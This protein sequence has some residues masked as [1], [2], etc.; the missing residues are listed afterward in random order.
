MR[1]L[2]VVCAVLWM[3]LASAGAA[4]GQADGRTTRARLLEDGG[5]PPRLDPGRRAGH[6]RAGHRQ[7]VRGRRDRGRGRVHRRE[8]RPLRR[9]RLAL[10]HRRRARRGPAGGV[11]ALHPGRRRLRRRARRERHRVHVELVRRPRRRVLQR[12]PRIRRRRRWKS[13]T[14]RT[15][16][17]STFRPAG[18]A[19]TSGTTSNPT[20]AARS[21]CSPRWTRRRTRGG[22]DGHRPPDRLVPATTRAVAPGTRACGHADASFTEP[23]FRQHLLGGILWAAGVQSPTTAA[24]RSGTTSRRSCSTTTSRARWGWTSRPT[25]A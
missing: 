1:R 17:P 5:V 12:P 23:Q 19:R 13:P 24:A 14:T 16:R 15:P 4:Y 7:R 11:R 9:G 21:T 3:C 6:S 2:M 25:A 20:R 18:R 22:G 10:D 8:P